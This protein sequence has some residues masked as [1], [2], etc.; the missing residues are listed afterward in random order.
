MDERNL[1]RS[2]TGFPGTGQ[3]ERILIPYSA[4]EVRT[5]SLCR[6]DSPPSRGMTFVLTESCIFLYVIPA[7][8]GIQCLVMPRDAMKLRC[9]RPGR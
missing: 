7:K 1:S 8:A 6:L 3:G 2:G 9:A 5:Q 4:K